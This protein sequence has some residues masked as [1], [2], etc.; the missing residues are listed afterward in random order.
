MHG[1]LAQ[2][3]PR[4]LRVLPTCETSQYIIAI[5]FPVKL[6]E[7]PCKWPLSTSPELQFLLLSLSPPL[8]PTIHHWDFAF[9]PLR[10]SLNKP[11]YNSENASKPHRTS[12]ALAKISILRTLI[13]Q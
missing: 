7:Q 3:T 5:H 6:P 8:Q 11:L 2:R 1:N 12:Q 13:E 10:P 4:G 9:G